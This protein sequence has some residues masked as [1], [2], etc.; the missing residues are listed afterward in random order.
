MIIYVGTESVDAGNIAGKQRTAPIGM[1]RGDPNRE[2]GILQMADHAA[3]EKSG[4]TKYGHASRRHDAKVSRRPGLRDH[5]VSKGI[6]KNRH[7][8]NA[9]G[10][11][12]EVEFRLVRRGPA[13]YFGVWP[14]AVAG[15][16]RRD[17]PI[18]RLD[19]TD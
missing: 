11:A 1:P 18:E 8:L 2:I 16:H 3:A 7:D 15:S 17:R 19:D 14:A 4:A 13:K 12:P 9:L 5:I 10:L 6:P